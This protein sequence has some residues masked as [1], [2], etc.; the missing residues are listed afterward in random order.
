MLEGLSE[1]QLE[2]E[3]IFKAVSRASRLC[4]QLRRKNNDALGLMV[5]SD[6]SPVTGTK[7]QSQTRPTAALPASCRY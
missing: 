7:R 1:L 6:H 2:I 3:T 4:K 5:K